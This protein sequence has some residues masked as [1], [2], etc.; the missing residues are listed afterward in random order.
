[1]KPDPIRARLRHLERWQTEIIR[2]AIRG[3]LRVH[4]ITAP[5]QHTQEAPEPPPGHP[6]QDH[7]TPDTRPPA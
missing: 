7:G 1:M 3:P 5:R 2:W 6:Q 4:L